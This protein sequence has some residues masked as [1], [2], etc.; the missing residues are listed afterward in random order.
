MMWHVVSTEPKRQNCTSS[1]LWEAKCNQTIISACIKLIA[2]I[3]FG[4]ILNVS[5]LSFKSLHYL[6][7]Y[8]GTISF[9]YE[10][11][12]NRETTSQPGKEAE[13]KD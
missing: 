2:C 12:K 1:S 4:S 8:K 6:S 9:P 11:S 3:K 10:C 7:M 5:L 13:N